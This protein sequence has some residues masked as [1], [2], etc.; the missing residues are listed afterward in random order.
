M[1][2]DW[3]PVFPGILLA[4]KTK[5][6]NASFMIY[7]SA[8]DFCTALSYIIISQFLLTYIKY[9]AV[10]TS[11]F[12]NECLYIKAKVTLSFIFRSLELLSLELI[13]N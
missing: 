10:Y 13:I 2:T 3:F 1:L 7:I 6:L 11:S 5:S 9:E 8:F 4:K 12:T